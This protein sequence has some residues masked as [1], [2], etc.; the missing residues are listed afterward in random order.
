MKCLVS[1]L[2][3]PRK[4]ERNKETCLLTDHHDRW[5]EGNPNL[6]TAYAFLALQHCDPK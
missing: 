6:V 5:H 4:R 2:K 1:G 3:K